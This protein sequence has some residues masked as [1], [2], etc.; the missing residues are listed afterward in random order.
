LANLS[1]EK[2]PLQTKEFHMVEKQTDAAQVEPIVLLPCPFCGSAASYMMFEHDHGIDHIADCND[3]PARIETSQK[4][5]TV[6]AWNA[7]TKKK[8]LGF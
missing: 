2:K 6:E 3:C 8:R 1:R 5:R 7:R 4:E